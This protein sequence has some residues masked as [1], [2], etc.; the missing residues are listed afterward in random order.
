MN[1]SFTLHNI[2]YVCP[3]CCTFGDYGGAGSVG[4][5]NIAALLEQAASVQEISFQDVY[6]IQNRWG[7]SHV[8]P[9]ELP[10]IFHASGSYGS[11][12][13][14]V[15]ADKFADE[16]AA[17]ADYPSLDDDKV[18]EIEMEAVS[19]AFDNWLESDLL[20][21]VPDDI[22][23]RL[24]DM[25][26]AERAELTWEAYRAAMERENVYPQY[27]YSGVYINIDRIQETFNALVAAALV[28]QPA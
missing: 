21:G 2:E 3:P 18:S 1:D 22:R 11:E 27:E 14:Y 24:Y 20:R 5:A 6:D 15:R 10:D 16:I 28:K 17:L 23:D 4:K 7:F 19:D 13:V 8:S 9:D 26:N 12:A 25:E